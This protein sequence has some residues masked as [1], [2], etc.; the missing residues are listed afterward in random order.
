MNFQISM[1][2]SEISDVTYAKRWREQVYESTD[3][4]TINHEKK[5]SD[6]FMVSTEKSPFGGKG[7]SIE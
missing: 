5:Y 4:Q 1:K 6:R 3:D 2:L 7:G